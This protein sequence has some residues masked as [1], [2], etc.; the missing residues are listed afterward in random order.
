MQIDPK[1]LPIRP[2]RPLCILTDVRH[3]GSLPGLPEVLLID[4]MMDA[5]T[6]GVAQVAMQSGKQAAEMIAARAAGRDM[7]EP[8]RYVDKGSTATISRFAAVPALAG[9]SSPGSSHG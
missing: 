1:Q 5:G 7:D 4:F 2:E 9:S 8:F 6:P 3:D